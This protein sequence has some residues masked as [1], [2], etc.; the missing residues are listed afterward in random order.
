VALLR[1]LIRVA[2]SVTRHTQAADAE[3]QGVPH[4]R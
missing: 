4:E 2:E 1:R 3:C